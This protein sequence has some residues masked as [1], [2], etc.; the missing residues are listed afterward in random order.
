MAEGGRGSCY[1]DLDNGVVDRLTLV[2]GGDSMC[3][4][5]GKDADNKTRCNFCSVMFHAKCQGIATDLLI[6]ALS[7]MEEKGC[8]TNLIVRA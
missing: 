7:S 2:L 1:G 5:C 4:K 3:G 6:S 8:V